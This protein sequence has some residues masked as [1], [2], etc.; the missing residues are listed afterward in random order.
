MPDTFVVNLTIT[1][2]D[3]SDALDAQVKARAGGG[4]LT[5]SSANAPRPAPVPHVPPAKAA[6][7]IV[8][9]VKP[10]PIKPPG[11]VLT[12]GGEV[13]PPIQTQTP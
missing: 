7:Q 1:V 3:A 10:I 9:N 2:D 8:T 4:N 12:S 5:A 13:K 6:P 11:T